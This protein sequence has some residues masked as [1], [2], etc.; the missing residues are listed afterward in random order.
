MV[1]PVPLPYSNSFFAQPQKVVAEGISKSRGAPEGAG[2]GEV[3]CE[4]D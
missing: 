2:G 3:P 1:V 4:L